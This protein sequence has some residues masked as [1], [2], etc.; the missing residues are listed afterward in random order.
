MSRGLRVRDVV[1]DPRIAEFKALL[2]ASQEE[3]EERPRPVTFTLTRPK[4]GEYPAN[5]ALRA[6]SLYCRAN[7]TPARREIENVDEGK[8]FYGE[9]W[10]SWETVEEGIFVTVWFPTPAIKRKTGKAGEYSRCKKTVRNERAA[11]RFE[12][13]QR[14]RWVR[15][16]ER[17]LRAGEYDEAAGWK[18]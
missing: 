14:R 17:L 10:A 13:Q 11:R 3:S 4:P 15:W 9:P 1:R 2:V 16:V 18:L 7:L 8:P 12:R 6:H 5:D